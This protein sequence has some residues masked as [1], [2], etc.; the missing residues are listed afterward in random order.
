[1]TLDADIQRFAMERM[2]GESAACVV[3][4]IHDGDLICLASSPGFDPNAFV[5][6][7]G[8][9]AFK[10]LNE[11][12]YK[13]LFHKAV[14]GAYKPGSTFKIVTA[15]A[16][17]VSGID[18]KFKVNCPGYYPFGGR[19]F[20]CWKRGGHGVVDMRRALQV[21]CNVFFYQAA[22]RAGQQTLADT[23]RQYGLGQDY[24]I[25]VPNVHAGLVPDQAWWAER[26]PNESW[27]PGMTL[28]TGIGQG[29]L[30]ATPLQLA[31]MTAR[32]ANG[33]VEVRPR[34][35]REGPGVAPLRP[36]ARGPLAGDVLGVVRDG[37]YDVCN[38]PGGTALRA[39]QLGLVRGPNGKVV[40]AAEAPPGAEPVRIAGKT[41]TAQVRV[42]TA[43]ERAR[44]VKRNEDLEWRLRDHALFVCYGPYDAPRYACA[45]VVE[46]GGGGSAKAAPIARDVMRQVLLRD[47]SAL[48][49]ATV[50]ALAQEANLAQ[51]QAP[52]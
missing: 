35:V 52:A 2:S 48:P 46:H 50:E 25:D 10:E 49:A 20:H 41:G 34:L 51:G 14:T 31:V 17:I 6:G 42:I 19:A 11:S 32:L 39:G 24:D 8:P 22:Q 44:G 1:L 9:T 15:S 7:I 3:M 16:A 43:A 47:P 5:N 26:R 30:L 13:P 45:I 29:D 27:P 36:S 12:E 23:A 37:C 33:G 18:P 28:N 40:D 38:T 4:D 21:S